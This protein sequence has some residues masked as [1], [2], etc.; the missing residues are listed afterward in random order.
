MTI[1]RILLA[2]LLTLSFALPVRADDENVIKF[3]TLAPEGSAWMRIMHE[4]DQEVQKRSGGK[5]K[6]K[7]YAGGVAGDESDVVRKI[8]L[9]QLH[10]GGFTGVGIGEIAPEVRLLDTP[11]LFRSEAEIDHVYKTFDRDWRDAFSKNGYVFLG[12]AEVGFVYAFTSK[13]IYD[14]PDLKG[15]KMWMWEGDPIAE[16]M[17]KVLDISPIPLSIADVMTSLQTGLIDGVY[18]SPLGILALQWYTRTNYMFDLPLANAS[19]AVVISKRFFDRL[20]KDQQDLL[21]STGKTYMERLTQESR[22]ENLA[23]L[24]TLKKNGVR[25]TSPIPDKIHLYVEAGEKARR[26]LAGK[27]YSADLLGRV[28]KSLQEFRAKNKKR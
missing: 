1:F 6:F 23:A 25:L 28:E 10:A 21:I 4:W 7:I 5:L 20:P 24:G 15:V 8:R 13:P 12:W 2:G 22:K 17:F 16:A 19:G 3:A 26:M 27:L 9:G 14:L 11:F 18:S